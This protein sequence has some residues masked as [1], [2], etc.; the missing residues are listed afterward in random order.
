[1]KCEYKWKLESI[2]QM[3][4]L[5]TMKFSNEDKILFEETAQYL[6]ELAESDRRALVGLMSVVL[7]HLLKIDYQSEMEGHSWKKSIKNSRKRLERL[8]D[9]M[10]SLKQETPRVIE[11]AYKY[12]RKDASEETFLPI[13]TFPLTCPYTI[14][15]IFDDEF[16]PEE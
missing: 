5:A 9:S 11:K 3:K 2:E 14:E 7:L 8:I 10:P 15:Q 16:F 4:R 6:T 1:M 13:A 12:A